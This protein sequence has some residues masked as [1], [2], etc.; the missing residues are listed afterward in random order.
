M[1]KKIHAKE[2]LAIH[3]DSNEAKEIEKNL[4]TS[5]V[6]EKNVFR[7]T[8]QAFFLGIFF[9]LVGLYV[10]KS[11]PNAKISEGFGGVNVYGLFLTAGIILM[12][13]F[14]TGEILKAVGDFIS[15]ARGG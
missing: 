1:K 15:K 10:L 13:W 8:N 6:V 7:I 5:I 14:K 2:I 4:K 12:S 9:L 3:P 11:F